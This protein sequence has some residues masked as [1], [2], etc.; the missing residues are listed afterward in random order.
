M[1]S[2]I[3]MEQ[4]DARVRD[5]AAQVRA[6]AGETAHI[7][8]G[9]VRHVVPMD[10][11][12]RF[13][14]RRIDASALSNLLEIDADNARCIAEPG[15]PF[16]E[17]VK[18]TV[19][20]GLLPAVVP[21]LKGITIGGAVAGCSVES[22]S[23]KVGGFHD[24]CESYE[25]IDG[26]GEIVELSRES[27]GFAFEMIHG[28]YGTL[29]VLSKLA[30]ELVPAQPFVHMTYVHY[31]SSE[32]FFEDLFRHCESGEHDFIDAIAHSPSHF[33]M[34][35]GDIEA[36]AP[37]T[38]DYTRTHAF[39]RSTERLEQDHLTT[40]DYCFR[41]DTD[42]HWLTKT[43]P[44]L[45]W[46]WVRYLLG[47]AMLGS[48]NL[49]KWSGRL[50]PILRMKK[51]PELVSDVFIPARRFL[52]FAKTY[53]QDF[54]FYPLWIVPYRVPRRYPWLADEHHARMADDLFIDC[55]VYG[56]RNNGPVDMSPRLEDTTFEHDGMKALIGRNHYSPERFW[57]IYNR[58]NYD[59]AKSQLDPT[60]TFPDLYT[61]L[62]N[63]G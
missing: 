37:Y 59:A 6:L 53:E 15:L 51:R 22:M 31:E 19:P 7:A 41:Y 43:A 62:G 32:T 12:P 40:F 61:K 63:T 56:M 42:A 11:D 1:A 48:T 46:R 47:P 21:E 2:V 58:V 10:R 57:S 39:Y 38:S 24:T 5:V 3:T 34:C 50:A 17:L 52:D 36:S 35:Q 23:Y 4:H 27:D 20:L 16:E 49:I 60:G 45:Q 29:G 18:A 9:G 55:A 28:S 54:G 8:K 13:G 30:F 44:P 33:V 26:R 14:G 25:L